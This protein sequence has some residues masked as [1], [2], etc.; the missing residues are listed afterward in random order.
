VVEDF[1]E[2]FFLADFAGV[3][4]RDLVDEEVFFPPFD[5]D[6]FFFMRTPFWFLFSA[7]NS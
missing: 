4:F 7:N 6:V 2:T 3:F 5:A 1:F